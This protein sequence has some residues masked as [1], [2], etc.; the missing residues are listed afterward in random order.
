MKTKEEILI[1]F[2]KNFI[3]ADGCWEWQGTIQTTGYGYFYLGRGHLGGVKGGTA[4]RASWYLYIGDIPA[5][6]CVCHRCDN[7][8]CVNPQHLFLGT[9]YDNTLDKMM[10]GRHSK[11]LDHSLK[12]KAKIPRGSSHYK[13]KLTEDDIQ[14]ICELRNSG[15]TYAAI[16]RIYSFDHTTVYKIIKNKRWK[17]VERSLI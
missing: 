16:A 12:T 9:D 15:M 11:G 8:K 14:N 1:E 7:R 6:M 17:H 13:T 3:K 2:E 10:K 4:S 5:G